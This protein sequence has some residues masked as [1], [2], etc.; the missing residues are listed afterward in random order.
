MG[1]EEKEE[2]GKSLPADGYHNVDDNNYFNNNDNR[3]NDVKDE[4]D[5]DN[6]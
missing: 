5:N 1:G 2:E 3:D 4:E 6:K